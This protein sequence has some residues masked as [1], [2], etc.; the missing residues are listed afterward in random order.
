M[1][2][3]ILG[4]WRAKEA[5][6]LMKGCCSDNALRPS[7]P[8]ATCL[9]ASAEAPLLPAVAYAQGGALPPVSPFGASG[10][11]VTFDQPLRQQP[12]APRQAWSAEATRRKLTQGEQRCGNEAH[13][14]GFDHFLS[15]P[16]KPKPI[17][18]EL[19]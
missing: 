19:P 18:L 6:R 3:E 11:Q 14:I 1:I 8:V 2:V 7:A 5:P 15:T 17:V 16:T 12:R 4:Q 10:S 13:D 9:F